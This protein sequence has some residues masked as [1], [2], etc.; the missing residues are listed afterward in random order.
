MKRKIRLTES[1]LNQIVRECIKE[2]ISDEYDDYNAESDRSEQLAREESAQMDEII[3]KIERGEYD[4]RLERVIELCRKGY[5]SKKFPYA[6]SMEWF[7]D[8]EIEDAAKERLCLIN[9]DY[10]FKKGSIYQQGGYR[11]APAQNNDYAYSML[12]NK[13][14]NGNSIAEG[15]LYRI[16]RKCVNEA[17]KRKR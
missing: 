1:M 2:S 7:P 6:F 8:E 5:Y 12:G 9:K 13:N 14:V 10:A 17:L 11:N 16:V 3:A 15:K 4:S